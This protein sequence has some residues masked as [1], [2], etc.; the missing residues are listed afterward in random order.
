MRLRLLDEFRGFL[1][2]HMIAY[3]FIWDLVYLHG[4]NWAWYM[5]DLGDNWGQMICRCFILLSGFCWQLGK[6]PLKRG[7]LVYVGGFVVTVVTLLVEPE[8]KVIFGI[9]TLLGSAMILMIPLD[10][11]CRRI[12]PVIGMIVSYGLFEFTYYLYRGY[13]GFGKHV[14]LELPKSWYANGFTTYL[15]FQEEGFFST[16]YFPIMPWFFLFVAGYFLYSLVGKK[17][18]AIWSKSI[19]PPLG[20]VGRNAFVIYLIHQPAIYGV[21][22]G[23]EMLGCL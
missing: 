13:L 6:K 3:H 2:I 16:D 4:K 14:W 15:G 1:V 20:W 22:T 12:P 5:S 18:N 9:L 11:I 10:L 23:L 8:S 19:C 21:L 17:G 7:L